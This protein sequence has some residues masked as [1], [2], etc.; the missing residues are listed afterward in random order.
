MRKTEARMCAH[1]RKKWFCEILSAIEDLQK[2][3]SL[4]QREREGGEE[5]KGGEPE[6]RRRGEE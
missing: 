4:P 5:E 2:K 6:K 3:K 1:R